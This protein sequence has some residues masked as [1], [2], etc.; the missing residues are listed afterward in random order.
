MEQTMDQTA[1]VNEISCEQCR[2]LLS[3]YVDREL[4]AGEK[5]SVEKHLT[6]CL[7][8][9]S[10]SARMVGL[11]K[12]VQNWQ[13]VRSSG[14][15]RQS[16]MQRMIRESQQVPS[17]QFTEAAAESARLNADMEDLEE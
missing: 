16:V 8:C 2:E 11:K 13:G 3:D 7:K 14:E 6:S 5:A 4:S 17:S 9:G 15:F 12:I 10:E 1:S